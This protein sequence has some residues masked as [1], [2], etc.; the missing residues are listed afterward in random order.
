M[1]NKKRKHEYRRLFFTRRVIFDYILII[2]I[3]S[4]FLFSSF[5]LREGET[6]KYIDSLFMSSSA[7]TDTSLKTVEIYDK[8]N[9]FGQLI[10]LVLIQIGGM[11]I[12]AF[13]ILVFIALRKKINIEDRMMVQAEYNL[14]FK[15]GIVKVI[16]NSFTVI[17]VVEVIFAII[18]TIHMLV[19]YDYS[20]IDSLWFGTFQSVSSINNA[21]FTLTS[22]SLINFQSDYLFQTYT[23]IL[24]V[25]GGL[26]FPFL[27]DIRSWFSYKFKKKTF[28][29]SLFSKINFVAYF[30]IGLIG[31]IF[32]FFFEY[33]NNILAGFSVENIYKVLFQVVSSRSAGF[34][35][36]DLNS[37]T[38]PSNLVLMILMFIGTAPASCGGGIRTTTLAVIVLFLISFMRSK[39][40]VEVYNRRLPGSVVLQSFITFTVAFI[41]IVVATFTISVVDPHLDFFSVGFD[42]VSAFGTSGLSSGV[43][44]ELS[45][46]SK[47]IIVIIMIIGQLGIANTLLFFGGES[48]DRGLIKPVEED[49]II[50]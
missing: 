16:K 26:G 21:G 23:I 38:S 34:Y 47:V 36:H 19:V 13:K 22:N 3:A 27:Y 48:K 11:G 37:F 43:T 25:I 31:F 40:S 14:S 41:L 4:L 18:F 50:G 33:K 9:F 15:S 49:L 8:F 24:I 45:Q 12:M 6:I 30:T 1:L 46:I 5:A 2:F 32:I 10:I 17:L 20:F 29:F 7:L 28:R 42:T 35:T 44:K 39:N